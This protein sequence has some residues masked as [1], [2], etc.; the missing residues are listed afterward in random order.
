MHKRTCD[1]AE[2]VSFFVKFPFDDFLGFRSAHNTSTLRSCPV[3]EILE[4]R[5]NGFTGAG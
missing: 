2:E 3:G 5:F 1:K 4:N